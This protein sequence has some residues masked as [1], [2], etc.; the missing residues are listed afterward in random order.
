MRIFLFFIFFLSVSTSFGQLKKVLFNDNWEFQA[1][2]SD[3]VSI[4]SLPHTPKLEPL[5]MKGQFIGEVVY[6]KRFDYQ[7][8]KGRRL[9]LHFEGAMHTASVALNGKII[10]SHVGG[11]LPFEVDLSEELRD[12]SNVLEVFLD[13]REDPTIPPGKAIK[14]L[15]FYYHAGIYRNVWL[16]EVGGIQ[17][18]YPYFQTI[19]ANP[20]SATLQLDFE[21]KCQPDLI[22]L[23]LQVVARLGELTFALTNI[24][25]TDSTNV[26]SYTG[27]I[28][29]KTPQLWSPSD[30]K[31]YDLKIDVIYAQDTIARQVLKVGIRKPELKDDGFYLNGSKLFLTGTNR[32]QEYPYV[33]NAVPDNAQ[34][35]DAQL[36][37]DAGF[38]F[39]RLSHYP[40]APAFYEACDE[41][42]LIV[43]DAIPGWQYL[44]T[45]SIFTQRCKNDL[46]ALTYRDRNHPSVIFWENSLNETAMPEAFMLDMNHILKAQIGS[47]GFSAGWLDH[48]SYD[49][50]IPARQHAKA[51]DYWANYKPNAKALFIAEYGDWEYYAQNAGF[52]QT[53][54]ADLA[55]TERNSRH[56]RSASEKA[57]LQ[58]AFNFQE[59]SNS[60]RKGAN[61]IGEAN[62]VCFDYNRGYSPDLEASGIYDIT[63]LP[64]YTKDFYKSQGLPFS[65][66]PY[67]S[68]AS[69]WDANSSNTVTVYSNCP[70]VSL[71]LNDK[72]IALQKQTSNEASTYLN[73]PPY[74]F[75]LPQFEPGKLK[76]YGLDQRQIRIASDEVQT[77]GKP[78]R[79][80][81]SIDTMGRSIDTLKADLI[82]IRAT[83]LDANGTVV[84]TN[85]YK[86]TFSIIA[87]DAGLVCPAIQPIEAG[88]ASALIRTEAPKNQILIKVSLSSLGFTDQLIWQP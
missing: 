28:N 5:V 31:L 14:E 22:I 75:V 79:I 9:L 85:D 23:P 69:R 41:L 86:V 61:S 32:H 7:L 15:D 57:L 84:P 78:A 81:L 88:I 64:K 25:F 4:V 76:A 18:Q 46:Y 45:S 16:E 60:N 10:G 87:Q 17:I 55:P 49:V 33:G 68:I 43:M 53:Q 52:N 47:N 20:S 77:P 27:K 62:W 58:Q 39:V 19:D 40:Q 73:A 29:Q 11:Y 67:V 82:F 38:N 44:N 21:L 65:K 51:P 26:I 66:Q 50:F 48:P 72:Q 83:L 42:G 13:N 24:S 63:R 71:F 1:K 36:I 70:S 8:Q 56:L 80:R 2:P 6:R 37:K 74:T 30:P 12:S 3:P 59:A 34:K 54:F 35:R